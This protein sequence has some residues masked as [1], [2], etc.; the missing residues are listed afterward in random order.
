MYIYYSSNVYP[1]CIFILFIYYGYRI[2]SLYFSYLC[3]VVLL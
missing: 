1:I 3:I 2:Y